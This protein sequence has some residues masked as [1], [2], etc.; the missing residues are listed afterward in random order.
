MSKSK[1]VKKGL[2]ILGVV[3]LVIC[4]TFFIGLQSMLNKF[5][6]EVSS[7]E[8]SNVDLSTID[9]GIYVGE[10]FAN[11]SVGAIV[12]VTV[13]NNKI[14]NIDFI[15]HKCGKGKKAEVIT[16]SVIKA[17]S[18][19]VDTVSG[20]TGSSTIILKAIENALLNNTSK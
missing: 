8:I 14:T 16:E 15:D 18:I 11:E 12:E 13:K 17:Q 19:K 3:L 20:A 10:Y 2:I 5:S 1:K 9:D 6:E 4:S 7:I